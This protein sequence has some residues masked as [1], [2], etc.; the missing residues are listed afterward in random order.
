MT[1][2]L[3]F[4]AMFSASTFSELKQKPIDLGLQEIMS[5]EILEKVINFAGSRKITVTRESIEGLILAADF[6][7][8][9][10]LKATIAGIV[11]NDY[12][13]L[14]V[15][16]SNVLSLWRLTLRHGYESTTI[17]SALESYIQCNFEAVMYD[18]SFTKLDLE[19]VVKVLQWDS[20]VIST[21]KKAFYA[22]KMWVD[23]D[24]SHRNQHFVRL[25]GCMRFDASVDAAFLEENVTSYCTCAASDDF[26]L[27]YLELKKEP[28]LVVGINTKPRLLLP[29]FEILDSDDDSD[30]SSDDYAEGEYTD[31]DDEEE[32]EFSISDMEEDYDIDAYIDRITGAM[33]DEYLSHD[34]WAGW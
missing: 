30:S 33:E 13:G 32:D 8:M 11:R 24:Y 5:F 9:D 29:V 2:S 21:E 6:F 3:Y 4:K 16:A 7:K 26:V 34:D 20:L 12:R 28:R 14:L 27:Q 23:H 1:G 15:N 18:L 17:A 25:L 22:M 10:L 31:D 19:S